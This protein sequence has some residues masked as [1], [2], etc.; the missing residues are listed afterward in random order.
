MEADTPFPVGRGNV[1]NSRKC[2][3]PTTKLAELFENLGTLLEMKGDSV[4]KIRAY[5]RAA[6]TI[7]Q[8]TF[9]LAQAR[10]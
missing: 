9:P 8:L 3:P 6:E 1:G 7:H 2:N 4:F 10:A 5:R